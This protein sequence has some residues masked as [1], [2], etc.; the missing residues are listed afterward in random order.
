LD[1][2]LVSRLARQSSMEYG[3]G[4]G[5]GPYYVYIACAPQRS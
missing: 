5:R 1:K 3:A 4:S 2:P